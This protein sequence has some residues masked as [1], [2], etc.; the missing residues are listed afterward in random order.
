MPDNKKRRDLYGRAASA[1]LSKAWFYDYFSAEND[2]VFEKGGNDYAS[3]SVKR[4]CSDYHHLIGDIEIELI[5]ILECKLIYIGDI[6]V[7][8]NAPQV[9]ASI[10]NVSRERG[11]SERYAR[12]RQRNA[13][14]KSL[15][16]DA[17]HAVGE[18]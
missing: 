15:S 4:H 16:S 2:L 6:V 9:F 14:A 10:E 12:R 5:A 13:V 1:L 11:N 18:N 17:E 7:Q 8:D 3:E